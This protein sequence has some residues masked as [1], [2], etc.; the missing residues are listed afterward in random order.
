MMA[1]EMLVAIRQE[2]LTPLEQVHYQGVGGLKDVE[3]TIVLRGKDGAQARLLYGGERGVV[4]EFDAPNRLSGFVLSELVL[5]S[6]R[7]RGVLFVAL[8]NRVREKAQP[9]FDD[10][11]TMQ[12][13]YLTLTDKELDVPITLPFERGLDRQQQQGP[14]MEL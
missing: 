8:E 4:L 7:S 13:A 11:P 9:Y 14:S 6:A 5:S 1:P 10:V 3:G 2:K 12:G